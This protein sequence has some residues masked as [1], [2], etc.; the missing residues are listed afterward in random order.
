L[1]DVGKKGKLN[2]SAKVTVGSVGVD[3]T[4]DQFEA[5]LI[6]LME[7]LLNKQGPKWH[8]AVEYFQ[9]SM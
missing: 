1:L 5:S 3:I 7:P 8:G 4:L 9:G 2:H 6:Q